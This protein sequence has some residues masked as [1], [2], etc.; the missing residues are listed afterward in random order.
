MS[1][2]DE[3]ILAEHVRKLREELDNTNAAHERELD[4]LRRRSSSLSMR[5]WWENLW[6][7][8]AFAAVIIVLTAVF[9]YAAFM[10]LTSDSAPARCVIV[11]SKSCPNNYIVTGYV[12]WGLDISA[13]PF[14]YY[15]EAVEAANDL[16]CN[17]VEISWTQVRQG[18]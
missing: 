5:L 15:E 10:Y 18:L 7:V 13:G 14:G 16:K 1:E 11:P 2:K 9:G 3:D 8:V 12:D 4:E 17:S 6:V